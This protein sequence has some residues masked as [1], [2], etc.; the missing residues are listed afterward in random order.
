MALPKITGNQFRAARTLIGWTRN[1][2]ASRSGL[3]RDVLRSWE[4]SS[5]SVIPAHYQFLCRAIEALAAA[6]VSFT[7]DGVRKIQPPASTP[8]ITLPSETS[9]AAA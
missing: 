3:S 1:D 9:G 7:D 2:L 5:D 8:T 4:V 6:G